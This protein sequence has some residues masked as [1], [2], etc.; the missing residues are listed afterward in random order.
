[1]NFVTA[2]LIGRGVGFVK[3]AQAQDAFARAGASFLARR[4]LAAR[5]S[6][7]Q[8]FSARPA[9]PAR[10]IKTQGRAPDFAGLDRP[11]ARARARARGKAAL[12]C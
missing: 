4:P 12:G 7:G 8:I 11:F 1:M 9:P 10:A 3:R 6:N 5:G 2:S